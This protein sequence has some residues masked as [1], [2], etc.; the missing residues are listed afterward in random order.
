MQYYSILEDNWLGGMDENGISKI[1]EIDESVF[2][3]RKYNL[4]RLRNTQ[5]VFGAIERGIKKCI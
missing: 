4:G 3:R 5:W 2:F 1:V